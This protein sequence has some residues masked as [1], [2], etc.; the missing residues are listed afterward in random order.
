MR[1][2]NLRRREVLT[3]FGGVAAGWTPV[4]YAQQP[5]RVKRI[6]ILIGTAND[7]PT[8]SRVRALELGL[9]EL[10]WS[11]GR[12]LRIEYR[13][14][15]GSPDRIRAFAKEL[16]DLAPDLIVAELTPVVAALMQHTRTIPIV[17]VAVSDPIRAGFVESFSRPGG[18]IT[19]FTIYETT[20]GGKWL[21]LLHEMAP[22][23]KRVAML[24][25]PETSAAGA[26]GTVYLQSI[27]AAAHAEGIELIIAPVDRPDDI[28]AALAAIAQEPGGGLIVMP[29]GFTAVNRHRIA[30]QATRLRIPAMFPGAASVEAGGLAS[31]GVD[32]PDMFRRAA[33]YVDRIL[34]GEKP[35]EL[36][37][38]APIKFQLVINLG[39]AKALGLTVP[40]SLLA[41]ADEVIE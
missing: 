1:S 33:S 26:S 41:T 19:G 21:Q 25:N 12:N 18:N 35:G 9:L 17:F 29:S 38:Q 24:F 6:G 13:W 22:S 32:L 10:G 30:S 20:L 27:E 14:A 23:L 39:T 40:P 28:D 8:Q 34:K 36:P 16:V 5:R 2:D 7:A 15:E 37:V 11:D 31:Y 3:L 4:A